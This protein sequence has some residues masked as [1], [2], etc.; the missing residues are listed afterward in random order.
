M[1]KAGGGIEASV[2]RG[3]REAGMDADQGRTWEGWHHHMAL[4]L[5]AVWFLVNETHRGQQLTPALTLPQVRYGL[6]M[7][8]LEEFCALSIASI[9]RHVQRQLLRNELARFYHHRTCNCLPP[10]K[11]R[12]DIQ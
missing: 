3:K 1:I 11:L 12:R 5:M 8:L 2:Q 6:S 9:C 7:L 10:K 4:T